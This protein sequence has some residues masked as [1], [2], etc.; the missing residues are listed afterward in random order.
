MHVLIN[1]YGDWVDNINFKKAHCPH[2]DSL[3]Q[4]GKKDL[5]VKKHIQHKHKLNII[6]L[7]YIGFACP[8]CKLYIPIE[9]INIVKFPLGVLYKRNIQNL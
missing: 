5:T 1:K 8:A 4:Y 7:S 2:C 9:L 6:K 3:I